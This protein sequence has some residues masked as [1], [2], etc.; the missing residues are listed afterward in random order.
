MQT[1]IMAPYL[2]SLIESPEPCQSN[3]HWHKDLALPF[4]G[5]FWWRCANTLQVQFQ[6]IQ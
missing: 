5:T 1:S 3:E 6:S 4:R 2:A